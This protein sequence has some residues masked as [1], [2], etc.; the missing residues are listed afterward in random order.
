MDLED[1]RDRPRCSGHSKY[2]A[3]WHRADISLYTYT[4]FIQEGIQ[5][6]SLF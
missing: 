2:L 4:V 6:V 1:R 3:N 5:S